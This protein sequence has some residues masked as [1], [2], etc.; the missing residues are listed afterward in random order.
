MI[1]ISIKLIEAM[2]LLA[3]LKLGAIGLVL[4]KL[5]GHTLEAF[6]RFE[7]SEDF[8]LALKRNWQMMGER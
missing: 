1:K 7:T 3:G 5:T 4:D 8:D 6:V 2:N